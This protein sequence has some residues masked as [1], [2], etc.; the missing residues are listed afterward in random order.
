[1]IIKKNLILCREE[2]ET[3]L[4]VFYAYEAISNLM[5]EQRYV[6]LVNK[7]ICFWKIHLS[8]LQTKIFIALGRLY[9]DSGDAFSFNKFIKLCRDNILEFGR[10][11]LA[12]RK[13]ELTAIRPAWLDSYLAE[14][15]YATPADIDKLALLAKPFNRKLKGVY[16]EI[17]SKV[18]AHAVHTDSETITSLF[19]GTNFG[20][21][22]EVLTAFWS[23][24]TQIWNLYENG[25]PPSFTIGKYSYKDEVVDSVKS[26]LLSTSGEI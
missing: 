11:G 1:M 24:Y 19:Q 2:V 15:Y 21:I 18:V 20:E 10:D 9:D 26:V 17:R 16:R 4:R 7:N 12:I 3:A 22:E 5:T 6:D 25:R 13:L 14:A 23:I 8:A